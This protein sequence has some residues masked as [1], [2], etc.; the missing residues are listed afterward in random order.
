MP[1]GT[2]DLEAELDKALTDAA[3]PGGSSEAG[4]EAPKV[5]PTQT[6]D[7]Q[8]FFEAAGRKFKTREEAQ[9]AFEHNYRGYSKVESEKKALE[10]RADPWF[11]YEEAL[12]KDPGLH[13]A[14]KEAEERYLA[15]RAKG[16]TKAEAKETSGLDRAS[17]ERIEKL[18]KENAERK[19]RDDA[20]RFER[21]DAKFRADH[22]DVDDAMMDKIY[23]V[24]R[25]AAEEEG[26]EIGHDRAYREVRIDEQDAENAKL[27][28]E[29]RRVKS[30]AD[31]GGSS[32]APAAPKGKSVNQ[33]VKHGSDAEF[34][35][36]LDEQLK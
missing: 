9:R 8:V 20:D 31:V 17:Q 18:E 33:I 22:K 15:E 5:Q 29:N 2:D 13:K 28:E 12:R 27:K 10:K 14:L 16:A 36:L 21:E 3:N 19:E 1:D 30:A 4:D 23:S 35:R 24:M 7:G 25:R 34:D 11:K 32:H 26:I 6:D